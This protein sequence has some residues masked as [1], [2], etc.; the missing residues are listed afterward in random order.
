[1]ILT[2]IL[3][4]QRDARQWAEWL[5]ACEGYTLAQ[6]RFDEPPDARLL[7]LLDRFG[8]DRWERH[9]ERL[10]SAGQ[11]FPKIFSESALTS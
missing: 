7:E 1:M 8:L 9:V 4:Q 5:E 11:N 6:L 2:H 10:E 3:N